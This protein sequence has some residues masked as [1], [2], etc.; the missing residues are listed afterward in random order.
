MEKFCGS[1]LLSFISIL[2]WVTNGVTKSHHFCHG[3]FRLSENFWKFFKNEKE[4]YVDWIKTGPFVSI[5]LSLS[6]SVLWM[7]YWYFP[8]QRHSSKR[9]FISFSS[10]QQ[11]ETFGKNKEKG[12][13]LMG[14]VR[15]W[16]LTQYYWN[17][18]IEKGQTLKSCFW[19]R[20]PWNMMIFQSLLDFILCV[21][22]LA[23]LAPG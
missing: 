20:W 2:L 4:L 6:L 16:S 19:K 17:I 21:Q 5:S 23:L 12:H 1:T 14:K 3:T 9:P 13:L 22:K 18:N 8:P 7:M 11:K 15:H 10:W